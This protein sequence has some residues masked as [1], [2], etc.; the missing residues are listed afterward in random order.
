[1]STNLFLL[2]L[3]F[4]I[5]AVVGAAF[6]SFWQRKKKN[7]DKDIEILKTEMGNEFRKLSQ[8]IITQAHQQLIS[9]AGEKL[10]AEK[11]EI[12]T[13][14]TNKKDQISQMIDEIRQRLLE[15]EKKLSR[16]EEERI[17]SFSS[18]K[19]ILIEHQQITK[20]LKQHTEGLK[21]IL[22]NN[23]LRGQFGEQVAEDLLKMAGFV[24]G[25]DY[26]VNQAQEKTETRPDF[27]V[28][29]PDKTKINIDVKFPYTALKK[30]TETDNE[31][32]KKQYLQQFSTDVKQ[33]IKQV[34]S[35]EYINPDEKTVDFVILF[36]PNEM[37]FSFIYERMNNVWEEAVRKK[38]VLA[39]PFSFTAILRMIKQSYTNFQYQENLS[40]VILLI[41]KFKQEFDKFNESLDVLGKR[42]K[43]SL[44]Q[45]DK[46]SQTRTR[47]LQKVID[48]I[49]NTHQSKLNQ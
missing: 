4:L 24:I 11:K 46:V 31:Q 27:I 30:Y 28:F 10:G 7:K 20:E 17:K 13:D 21:K 22:S 43:S 26:V 49:E 3:I 44:E 1:M 16:S 29:L 40:Q 32:D 47:Q 9:M 19:S 12:R 45:Y 5:I 2:I 38:V 15:N 6:F 39:G 35:R 14:L 18:L 34:T 48:K 42:I 37:I 41:Q 23:Q 36:I 33:K 8:E 25:Q